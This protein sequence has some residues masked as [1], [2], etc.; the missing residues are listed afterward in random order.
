[1]DGFVELS[2]LDPRFA[3]IVVPLVVEAIT[4]GVSSDAKRALSGLMSWVLAT[5]AAA[6][7]DG[8]VVANVADVVAVV[9]S[10]GVLVSAVATWVVAAGAYEHLPGMKSTLAPK[11]AARTGGF[12]LRSTR[13]DT[14]EVS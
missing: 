3:A 6:R 12:G 9:T 14:T 11:V 10:P 1:M 13:T 7:A 4:N 8:V 2:G 5:V